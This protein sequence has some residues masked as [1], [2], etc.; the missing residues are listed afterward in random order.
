VPIAPHYA[1]RVRY[2]AAK[3]RGLLGEVAMRPL[4]QAVE[5]TLDWIVAQERS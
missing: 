5:E 3:L 4:K 1:R 2:R